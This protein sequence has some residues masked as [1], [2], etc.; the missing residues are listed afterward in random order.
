M[1]EFE[2]EGNKYEFRGEYRKPEQGELFLSD[3]GVVLN[4]NVGGIWP[5]ER[6][7]VKLAPIPSPKTV[8]IGGIMW[9]IGE[10]RRAEPGEWYLYMTS[11][12]RWDDTHPTSGIYTVVYPICVVKEVTA[13]D[14]PF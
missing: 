4:N 9:G 10:T 12:Q 2:F 8:E 11:V 5:A 6:A 7:I 1:I 13:Y 3:R 14:P